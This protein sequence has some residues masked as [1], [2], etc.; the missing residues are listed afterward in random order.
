M[1]KFIAHPA[2]GGI[3]IIPQATSGQTMALFFFY[4]LVN[5]SL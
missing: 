3:F 5:K 2:S 4:S 1:E